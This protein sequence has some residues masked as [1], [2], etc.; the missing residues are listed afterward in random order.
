MS[1]WRSL[2][3]RLP[4]RRPLTDSVNEGYNGGMG[5]TRPVGQIL[6]ELRQEHGQS[7][8]TAARDLGVD[9]AYLSRVER[10]TQPPSSALRSRA[11]T[12][13]D[14]DPRRLAF[15]EGELPVDV[16]EI[17][18]KHPELIDELRGRYGQ[19]P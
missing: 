9:P 16:L 12:Y 2:M 3:T 8:R 5:S 18:A 10:G 7:L 15:A 11:A 14:S 6:R 1:Q 19:A 17:L 4:S 13:Y